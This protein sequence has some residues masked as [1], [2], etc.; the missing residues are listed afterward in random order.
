[1]LQV[2]HLSLAVILQSVTSKG[3]LSKNVLGQNYN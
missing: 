3:F 1:M 2:F